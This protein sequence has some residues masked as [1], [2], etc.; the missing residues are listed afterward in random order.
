MNRISAV[1]SY[2]T[3]CNF[4]R[5]YGIP[6]K[7]NQIKRSIADLQKDIK[8]YEKLNNIQNGLYY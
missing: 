5:K 2:A 7:K 4:A 3:Y 1:V 6:V 8:R